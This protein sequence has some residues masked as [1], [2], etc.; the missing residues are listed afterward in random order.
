[1][2]VVIL[3][4]GCVVIVLIILVA[5]QNAWTVSNK[6]KKMASLLSRRFTSSSSDTDTD[7][8]TN[9]T[10]SATGMGCF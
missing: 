5:V 3:V 8:D 9:S 1:M 2:E 10:D 4:V 6:S 7:T